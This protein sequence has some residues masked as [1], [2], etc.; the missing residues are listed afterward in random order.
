PIAP[1]TADAWGSVRLRTTR[2][3]RTASRGGPSVSLKDTIIERLGPLISEQAMKST[4]STSSTG[5]GCAADA[6]EVRPRGL[7][8]T[9]RTGRA[10]TPL[11]AKGRAW[12]AKPD[13]I[14][15]AGT[16]MGSEPGRD[17]APGGVADGGQRRRRCAAAREEP[18]S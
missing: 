10:G 12:N 4:G 8:T 18:D 15:D 2:G 9:E 14:D 7:N 6:R 11:W 13:S 16:G 5:R 17:H 3:R 1:R